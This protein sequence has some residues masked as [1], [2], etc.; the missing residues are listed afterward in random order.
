MIANEIEITNNFD[1][2]LFINLEKKKNKK[3]KIL[4]NYDYESSKFIDLYNNISFMKEF[5]ENS[6]DISENSDL[7][8]YIYLTNISFK[9]FNF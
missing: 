1:I 6:S 4:K 2:I 3:F 8:N 9:V 5:D 7:T